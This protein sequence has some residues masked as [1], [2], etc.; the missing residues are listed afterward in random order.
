MKRVHIDEIVGTEVLAKDIMTNSGATLMISGTVIKK[1][2]AQKLKFLN[3]NDVYIREIHGK[4]I[5]AEDIKIEEPMESK[6]K[7]QCQQRVKETIELYASYGIEQ[8]TPIISIAD[9]II[10]DI[11]EQPE[12]VYNICGIREKSEGVFAHCVNVCALS[13]LIAIRMKVPLER[14][15]EIAIG[16]LLHDIGIT[17]YERMIDL[18][19]SQ[20]NEKLHI[21][22]KKHVIY[23][24]S[25]VNSEPWI[26]PTAKDIVLSHHER[27]NGSGY[28]FGIEG[29]KIKKATKIVSVCDVFDNLV[30]GISGPRYKVFEAIDYIVSQAGTLFDLTVVKVFLDTVA[31]YPNG[32]VVI[33]NRGDRAIVIRQN[34]KCPTRPVIRRIEDVNGIAY[35]GEKD[36]NLV[37]DLTL[38]I[39]DAEL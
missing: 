32:S 14:I 34:R 17:Y 37:E 20:R 19:E 35:I 7:M 12:V 1:E 28:P 33:T 29:K 16:S 3:I 23:G 38:F 8:L 31:A 2:Y 5:E 36:L 13:V 6:I 26:S 27:L 22:F 39:V 24:Y 11:L 9:S 21:E 30:Y 18:E 15:K 4:V 25:I 10:A